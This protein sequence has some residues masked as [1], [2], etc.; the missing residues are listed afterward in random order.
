MTFGEADSGVV[1]HQG[2]MVKGGRGEGKRVVKQKLAG[3][4]EKQVRATDDFGN[5][6]SAVVHKNGELIGGNIVVTPDDEVAEIFS[7]DEALRAEMAIVESDWLVVRNSKSP[8]EFL[9]LE[10]GEFFV[11]AGAG[12]NRLVIGGVRCAGGGLDVFAGTGAWV[13]GAGLK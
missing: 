2:A 7:G 12:I 1:G 3:G 13:Y 5:P 10:V 8:R 6:H 11:A 4:G 9:V